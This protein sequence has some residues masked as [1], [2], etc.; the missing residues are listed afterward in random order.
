MSDS[1]PKVLVSGG[2]GFVG[3][4]IVRAIAEKYPDVAITVIDQSPPRPQ[5]VLPEHISCMQIDITSAEAVMEAFRATM[6]NVV[7]HTGGLIPGLAERFGRQLEQKAWKT[8]FGGTRNMLDAAQQTGVIAFVYT[9]TCC[10][11]T[12]DTSTPHPNITEEWPSAARSTIYGESKAVAEALVLKASSS[13]MVTCALRPSVLCGPGDCQLIPPIHACIAKYETPF[14]IGDGLNLWDITH[15]SNV[16]DAHILA[17][18]NLVSSRTAAGECFFIQNN[19][20]IT[21]R[22]LCLAI[23][24]HFWHIPPFE[25][26]IPESL[27]HF[28]GLA[29]ETVTWVMGTTATLSRGTVR[30]AC[31][32]RYASGEKA[33][34]I[35]G[36]EARIGIEEG[37]RLS[38]EDYASRLGVKLPAESNT[39]K[40]WPMRGRQISR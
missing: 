22:D 19:E 24:A 15:V 34:E 25:L 39:Q 21:F 35:L 2:T 38:C 37:I 4:A 6:P 11:V 20:P 18:E 10:V 28:A 7:V 26:R 27:A 14:L 8:N 33:K 17:I 9:S 36:Y 31:A 13:K 30:D 29:C 3:S 5:H 23:W 16:A 1:F 40:I 12:D 32:I